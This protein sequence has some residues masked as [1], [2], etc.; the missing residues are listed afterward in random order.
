MNRRSQ[1]AVVV[2]WVLAFF[3]AAGML[4]P[5]ISIAQDDSHAD[6]VEDDLVT[7]IDTTAGLSQTAG[8]YSLSISLS[9]D[10]KGGNTNTQTSG[11]EVTVSKFWEN[12][13]GLYLDAAAAHA[14]TDTTDEE[15]FDFDFYVNRKLSDNLSLILVEEWKRD[16][17]KGLDHQNVLGIGVLWSAINKNK[18]SM[19][20]HGAPA[21]VDETYTDTGTDER[22]AVG[23]LELHNTFT[24]SSNTQATLV[25]SFYDN[26]DNSEDYRFDGS[27]EIDTAINSIFSLTL[28]YDLD[29]DHQPVSGSFSTDRTFSASLTI[30]FG[31]KS[32]S[33]RSSSSSDDSTSSD[34][35]GSAGSSE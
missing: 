34:D 10:E 25:T 17:F 33:S 16:I 1:E 9:Y 31:G 6:A 35:S 5:G 27:F 8:P 2:I 3:V 15:S 32:D 30:T 22:F 29:Y 21:R 23:L 12:K 24:I 28:T 11:V 19:T 18:W 4:S 26:F 20:I 14:K 13:W 7:K